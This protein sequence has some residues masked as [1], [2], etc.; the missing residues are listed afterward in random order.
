MHTKTIRNGISLSVMATYAIP[1]WLSTE[2]SY[3]L[4]LMHFEYTLPIIV[5]V[6]FLLSRELRKKTLRDLSK[7]TG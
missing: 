2:K 3:R 7:V 1:L 4:S 5:E 6:L